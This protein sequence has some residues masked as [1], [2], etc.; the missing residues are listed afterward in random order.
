MPQCLFY[1]GGFQSIDFPY[2]TLNDPISIDEII[3]LRT[4]QLVK[5]PQRKYRKGNSRQSTNTI[6]IM[7]SQYIFCTH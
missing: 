6:T 1:I 4:N 3:G 7:T 2:P 5:T